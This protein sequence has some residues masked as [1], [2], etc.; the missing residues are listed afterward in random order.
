MDLSPVFQQCVFQNHT[1]RQEEGETRAFV[2]HS[3]Q[4]QFFAQF[5]VVTFLCFFDHC[6]VCF[7]FGCFRVSCTIDSG[8]HFV[9]FGT[10]PVSTSY[11]CQFDCFHC[12][13][14]HQVRACAQVCEVALFVE[15]DNSIFGQILNQFYFVR[16]FSFFHV[17]DC[18]FSGQ[19]E[20]FDCDIFFRNFLHFCFQSFQFF[21]CESFF[22]VEIIVEAVSDSGADR[23][24]SFGV[25]AF[26]SLCQHM[27]CCVAECQF[28]GFIFECADRNFCIFVYNITQIFYFA[29]NDTCAS[30]SCQTFADGFCDFQYGYSV[31][32]FFY[33]AVFQCDLHTFSLLF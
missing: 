3:E 32:K 8:Q 18:F 28:A 24:F 29:V 11:R 23:N 1:F 15:G 26:Y 9:L 14:A 6:Q 19:F 10:S 27:R 16:F 31:I 25:Q 7:Q 20:F 12:F 30:V 17:F 13:C 4:F 33:Y 22:S 5:S 21:L 2:Q